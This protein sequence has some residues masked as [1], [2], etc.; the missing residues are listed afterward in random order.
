MTAA[1]RTKHKKHQ[2]YFKNNVIAKKTI[3]RP[4]RFV[5]TLLCLKSLSDKIQHLSVFLV[6]TSSIPIILLI[7]VTCC[8]K[9][10]WELV[11]I[12]QKIVTT[13]L[14]IQKLFLLIFEETGVTYKKTQVKRNRISFPKPNAKIII[15][16]DS[17][18]QDKAQ[19]TSK[20]FKK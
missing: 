11:Y 17:S 8:G 12:L 5:R 13:N 1:P 20:I 15:N 7:L 9:N 14:K 3:N 6:M 16:S 10:V 18:T 4:D 19:K 2:K